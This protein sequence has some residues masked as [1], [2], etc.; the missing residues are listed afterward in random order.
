MNGRIYDPTLGRFLQADP[1]IQAPKN[2][3]S[4]SRYSYVLNKPVSYTD[5][6]G[7]F[8]DKVFKALNKAFGK[9]APYI[10]MAIMFL[11]GGGLGAMM[12]KGIFAGGISTGSLRGAVTAALM[13]GAFSEIGNYYRGRSVAN[14]KAGIDTIEFGGNELTKMQIAGQIASHA[15]VGGVAAELQGGKFGHGFVSAGITKSL[16]GFFLPA[17]DELG[18]WEVIGG[19]IGSAVIGGTASVAI[20]GKFKNGAQT[21]AFQ[22][23]F[24]QIGAAIEKANLSKKYIKRFSALLGTLNE[25][26]DTV[27]NYSNHIEWLESLSTDQLAIL[28]RHPM[29][30]NS[31]GGAMAGAL[32]DLDPEA[33]KASLLYFVTEHYRLPQHRKMLALSA[34]AIP[35]AHKAIYI[36]PAVS[37]F[38]SGAPRWFQKAY[39]YYSDM[40]TLTGN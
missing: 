39:G 33:Y 36:S 29:Y 14:Q 30:G 38:V 34:E 17:G 23:M 22:Y 24:N 15:A 37:H 16:E 7:F 26:A 6:S 4:Y 25:M 28:S 21:A 20:G 3:Q 27:G 40:N 31:K 1:H 12:L 5:P 2:S 13:A 32:D 19:T 18:T 11:P 8:F 9:L 35:Q 10:G